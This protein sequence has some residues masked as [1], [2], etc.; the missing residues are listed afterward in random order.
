MKRNLF[1]GEPLLFLK[2]ALVFAIGPLNHQLSYLFLAMVIDLIFGVQVALKNKEFKMN[3]LVRKFGIKLTTYMLWIT[4]FHA[5][6][7]IAGLPDTARWSLIMVLVGLEIVSA[8][9]N[10]AS[11]GY[12]RLAEALEK[13]YL[14][15]VKKGGPAN[16][17]STKK[18]RRVTKPN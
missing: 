5:F 13:L 3:T 14:N 16:E 4:M 2:G 8:I 10:T 9:K 11:L 1:F 7:M 12:N 17:E 6:D 18:K 15:L